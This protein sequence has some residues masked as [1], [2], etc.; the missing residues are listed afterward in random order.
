MRGVA[1][2]EVSAEDPV[3]DQVDTLTLHA[4]VI[5]PE[6]TKRTGSGGISYQ[7]DNRR[8]VLQ[9]AE[10]FRREEG[11]AGIVDLLPKRTVKFAWMAAALVNLQ[12]ELGGTKDDVAPT[13]R[14]RGCA[15]KGY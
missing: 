11:G 15:Q 3:F 6:G 12:S 9:A 1:R 13:L 5:E 14:A 4:F 2:T 7:I 10:F 8:T